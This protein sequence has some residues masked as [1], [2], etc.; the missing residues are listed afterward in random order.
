MSVSASPRPSVLSLVTHKQLLLRGGLYIEVQRLHLRVQ[1]LVALVDLVAHLGQRG[2]QGHLVPL[3][4]LAVLVEPA[5]LLRDAL[6][7]GGIEGQQPL[8]Q[9]H[10]QRLGGLGDAVVV[11]GQRHLHLHLGQQEGHHELLLRH[12][13]LVHGDRRIARRVQLRLDGVGPVAQLLLQLPPAPLPLHIVQPLLLT[14]PRSPVL[15]LHCVG[16]QLAQQRRPQLLHRHPLHLRRELELVVRKQLG[17]VV[18]GQSTLLQ[19][20]RHALVVDV[21]HLQQ[22][23]LEQLPVRRELVDLGEGRLV[24]AVGGDLELLEGLQDVGQLLRPHSRVLV[25]EE[26]PQIPFGGVGLAHLLLDGL[27]HELDVVHEGG[28]AGLHAHRDLLEHGL[29]LLQVLGLLVRDE[30]LRGHQRVLP[31]VLRVQQRGL[32]LHALLLGVVGHL[33]PHGHGQCARLHD[34]LLLLLVLRR[35]VPVALLVPLPFRRVVVAVLVVVAL[36]HLLLL[37]V[38][39]GR[40]LLGPVVIVVSGVLRFGSI[41][42]GKVVCGVVHVR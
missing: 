28:Q 42:V 1:Q 39:H 22:L 2:V 16:E 40:P 15:R 13:L 25:L 8:L 23:R 41:L 32:Q 5:A 17:L 34:G 18:A 33:Q 7:L 14:G 24:A 35:V 31:P 26:P 4:G 29:A 9:L 21:A 12:H 11:P 30:V 10:G 20:G 37:L 19:V 38:G 6:L 27:L 3:D 36:R